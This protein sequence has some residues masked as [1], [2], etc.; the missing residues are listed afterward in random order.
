MIV[1]ATV[2]RTAAVAE[3]SSRAATR[4]GAGGCLT[5]VRQADILRFAA[6]GTARDRGIVGAA[7]QPI[8]AGALGPAVTGASLAGAILEIAFGLTHAAAGSTG[9]TGIVGAAG[10]PVVAGALHP[11]LQREP[12]L[13]QGDDGGPTGLQ[14]T[15]DGVQVPG[16]PGGPL[17]SFA[18]QSNVL[19]PQ[20]SWVPIVHVQP[21]PGRDGS[22][23]TS[24]ALAAARPD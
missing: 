4:T 10:E 1:L 23:Q 14:L 9:K 21:T 8:V 15:E 13:V 17:G 12:W 22:V 16:P 19:S 5:L 6:A 2:A 11:P 18:Q 20:G 24:C 3:L 7:D